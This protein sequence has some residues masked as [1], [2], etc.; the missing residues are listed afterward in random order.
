M[1]MPEKNVV[2][3]DDGCGFCRRIVDFAQPKIRS[4]IALDFVPLLSEEAKEILENLPLQSQQVDSLIFF[5]GRKGYIY[6]SAALKCLAKMKLPFAVWTPLVWIIPR[7]IRDFLYRRVAKSR[8]RFFR[9]D[10]ECQ[11][12]QTE[13]EMQQI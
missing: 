4:T 6:S 11:V 12:E 10:L 3:F 1:G 2:L 7:P 8:H 9:Q 5:N 13:Q